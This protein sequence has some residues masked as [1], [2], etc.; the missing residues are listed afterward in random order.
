[1]G[2]PIVKR[3]QEKISKYGY[4]RN[5]HKVRLITSGFGG[6]V[7]TKPMAN[8]CAIRTLIGKSGMITT[9]KMMGDLQKERVHAK[10]HARSW[11]FGGTISMQQ[12]IAT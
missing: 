5:L 11:A 2:Q 8:T 3:G 4:K 12:D 1:M 6:L 9:F 10:A 7:H